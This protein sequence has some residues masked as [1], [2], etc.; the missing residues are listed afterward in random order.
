MQGSR[1]S[2]HDLSLWSR[3]GSPCRCHISDEL[4][5]GIIQ[6]VRFVF[7]GFYACPTEQRRLTHGGSFD[8]MGL[9]S[10]LGIYPHQDAI[11]SL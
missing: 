1:P 5:V 7:G 3:L 2:L 8:W 11:L 4:T 9:K 10:R 6:I